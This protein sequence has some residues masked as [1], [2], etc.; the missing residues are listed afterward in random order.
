M[1]DVVVVGAGSAGL[2]AALVLGRARRQ[3]LV[4]DGGQ[5]RNAPSPAAHSFFTRD[6]T[7]PA[8]LLEI[9]RDQLLPYPSVSVRSG[10]AIGARV[11][12]G[13]FEVSLAE[14]GSVQCRKLLLAYG[15]VDDLPPIDGLRELWGTSAVACPFCHGWEVRDEPLAIYGRGQSGFELSRLL[16]G[17]SRDLVLCAG[18]P[19]ELTDEQRDGLVRNGVAIREEPVTRLDGR[20]GVLERIVFSD[21]SELP[22]R[23]LFLRPAQRPSSDLA[24]RLGCESTDLGLVRTDEWGHT[25]VPGVY[26]AGDLV[27]PMQQVIRAA[28]LGASAAAP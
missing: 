12:P 6:G 26:A 3:T 20:E 2:S 8:K 4:L 27:T 5:P 13:G 7:P 17:W 24:A 10:R 23:A 19:A 18:G 14:G 21:G 9:G 16:L 15:V 25:S 1:L 28:A 22:R 11:L